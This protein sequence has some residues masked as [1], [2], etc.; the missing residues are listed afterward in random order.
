MRHIELIAASILATAVVAAP[1]NGRPLDSP[2]RTSAASDEASIV[3]SIDRVAEAAV[4][5]GTS[6][7]LQIAV[8]KN[9]AAV[10]VKGY[11][12]ADLE[13]RTPV[14]NDS[15][16]RIGSVTKQFTAAAILKLQEE[17]RLSV[18]DRLAKYFP[19][20]PGAGEITLKQM[21][22]HTSGLHNFT[23]DDRYPKVKLVKHSTAELIAYFATMPKL[24]DF[25]P[26][27][28]WRYSNTAYCMLSAIVEKVEG[29][30]MAA[31][32]RR[33]FFVPLGMTRTALDDESEIVP[34]RV[35]GYAGE[36]PGKFQNPE[37]I[38]MSI[39]VGAGAMRST[40]TD[41]ARWNA[42]LFGGKV[43]EPASF[44]AMTAPG[45]LA[46][47]KTTGSIVSDGYDVQHEYGFA[48]ETSTVD[49]HRKVDHG[50]GIDG[51]SASLAEFPQ[52][53]ITVAILSNA[54][55]KD[56][57]VGAVEE[58]I[59][60]IALGLGAPVHADMPA[61]TRQDAAVRKVFADLVQPGQPGCAV[62]V[63]RD[64]KLLHTSAYG[65]GDMVTRAPIE[66]QSMFNI[67]SISKQFTAFSI[68]LLEQRK[69]LSIDDPLIKYVPELSASA[70]GVTLRHLIHHTGGLRDYIGLLTLGGRRTTDGATHY[71]AI[72]LLGRQHSGNEPPG[73]QFEYSNSGY[74]LLGTV[75]ERVS[76]RSMKQF[77]AENIFQP[78]GMQHTT[79]V[80][81]YPAG[82]PKL[83]NGYTPNEQKSGFEVQDAAWEQVGDGQIHTTTSDL[84]LWANNLL[85]GRVGGKPLVDRMKQVGVLT[86]GERLD[87]AA[88]LSVGERNGLPT[89][90]HGGGWPGYLSKLLVF[91][92]QRFAVDVLCNRDDARPDALANAVAEIYLADE[93]RRTGKKSP[94]DKNREQPAPPIARWQPTLAS[95]EGAYWSEEGK[96]RCVLV[97]RNGKLVVEGCMPGH[98]LQPAE[99]GEFYAPKSR[100]RLRF[101]SGDAAGFTLH[102][103]GLNG[104]TFVRQ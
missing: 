28:S 59:Q 27:T 29:E 5:E 30:P 80:D 21:L 13:Q 90:G 19:E 89:I 15:V 62:G 10:L 64:G 34:G 48:L 75:V 18:E 92:E 63:M 3:E 93:M 97:Q 101:G 74:I 87:Y 96:A 51:F 61:A 50:G 49:G 11:G 36:G 52:D 76:G 20:F 31:V 60:R 46:N 95:Y 82:L 14:T 6:V 56:V 55:G 40:A 43:L 35:Q 72:Q 73:K 65:L 38:S 1:V 16:F 7:G 100:A 70:S 98:E 42:A 71:E 84:L 17:G 44:A 22:Q 47:G 69:A 57:G 68:L 4:S 58:R 54:I 8:Y 2:A 26:G 67:A 88:G 12:L 39:P 32:L 103:Y 24:R 83:V 9:G 102:T 85:T 25:E 41:L 53:R 45:M 94:P 79:L 86:S 78:L 81:R 91:P 77:L 104:L 33:R 66:A 23:G 99:E 37:F